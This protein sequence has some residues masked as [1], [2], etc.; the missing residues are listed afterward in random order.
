[1]ANPAAFRQQ[2]SV[3]LT[4]LVMLVLLTLI[5]VSAINSTNSSVRIVGNQQF[6]DEAAAA[7]QKAID[8]VISSNFTSNPVASS[9]P[10]DINSDGVTD[11]TAQVAAPT[12]T[13]SA[14]IANASLNMNDPNDAPCYSASSA[15]ATGIMYASGV[16]VAPNM[17]WCFSQKW[18]VA[19]TVDD[20]AA[21]GGKTGAKVTVN[22]GVSLRV[23]A[24]TICN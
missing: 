18:N 21:A 6:R 13:G 12:C 11:Y 7:D 16:A 9:L 5:A 19:A 22:Q 8:S 20:S 1:M 15:G 4:A 10:V 14:P 23:P 3:L 17:S 24:G 2:G